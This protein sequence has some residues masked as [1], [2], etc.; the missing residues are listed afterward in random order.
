MF[1]T[2][3]SAPSPTLAG[4]RLL[5]RLRPGTVGS[6]VADAAFYATLSPDQQAKMMPRRNF[7]G[8]SARSFVS[9]AAIS[10]TQPV[11]DALSSAPG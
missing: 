10:I 1:A 9:D 4:T 3:K 2:F 7:S 6:P 11:P 8:C 5:V